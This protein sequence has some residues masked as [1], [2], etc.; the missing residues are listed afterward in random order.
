MF[1]TTFHPHGRIH[2]GYY[3]HSIPIIPIL[4]I[5]TDT[6]CLEYLPFLND[7]RII[8]RFHRVSNGLPTTRIELAYTDINKNHLQN[9]KFLSKNLDKYI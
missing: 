3:G 4:I 2:H 8:D 9:L 5:E 6:E 7:V 1:R